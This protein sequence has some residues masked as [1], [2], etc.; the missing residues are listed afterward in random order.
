MLDFGEIIRQSHPLDG[1]RRSEISI[2]F[3]LGCDI[4]FSELYDAVELFL[5]QLNWG[6]FR[7]R[8][9]AFLRRASTQSGY[10]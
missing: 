2:L 8:P 7:G 9:K 3:R 1:V 10:R 5:L 4:D 6:G